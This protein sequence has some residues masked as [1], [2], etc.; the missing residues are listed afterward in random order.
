MPPSSL[1]TVFTSVNVAGWSS[2]SIVQ[3]AVT[4]GV[5]TSDE[6]VSVRRVHDQLLAV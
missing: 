1:S 4:P 3:V 6:P 2:L 5:S